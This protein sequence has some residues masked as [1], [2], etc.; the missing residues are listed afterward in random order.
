MPTIEIFI[1]LTLS[2]GEILSIMEDIC[3][4]TLSI[5]FIWFSSTGRIY[6]NCIDRQTIT[7]F[8]NIKNKSMWVV[9]VCVCVCVC[10]FGLV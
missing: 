8:K 1:L 6:Q 2:C 7:Y 4:Q 3:V 10:C 9:C 5:F